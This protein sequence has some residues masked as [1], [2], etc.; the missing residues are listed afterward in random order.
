LIGY[1]T[2]RDTICQPCAPAVPRVGVVA[3]GLPAPE[4]P[5]M[6]FRLQPDAFQSTAT[7]VGMITT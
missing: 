1:T 6:I 7:T 3:R 2:R 4:K 5:P